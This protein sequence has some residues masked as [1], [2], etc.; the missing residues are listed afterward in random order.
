MSAPTHGATLLSLVHMSIYMRA[1]RVWWN[2]TACLQSAT[3]DSRACFVFFVVHLFVL[4]RIDRESELGHSFQSMVDIPC[5]CV[6][7]CSCHIIA[8]PCLAST[9]LALPYRKK[10]KRLDPTCPDT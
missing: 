9:T 3:C 7:V 4:N 8:L 2:P 5:V 1:T 10:K 6:C